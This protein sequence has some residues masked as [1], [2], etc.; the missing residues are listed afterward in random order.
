MRIKLRSIRIISKALRSFHQKIYSLLHDIGFICKPTQQ[1]MHLFRGHARV[2]T[3]AVALAFSKAAK[4]R[5]SSEYIYSGPEF[6]LVIWAEGREKASRSGLSSNLQFT[7]S[8][9]TIFNR[10]PDNNTRT[11]IKLRP[12]LARVSQ[13]HISLYFEPNSS[14][15]FVGRCRLVGFFLESDKCQLCN[16]A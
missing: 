2:C 15:F 11:A 7:R 4:R 9:S 3:R 1:F 12:V 6:T 14:H 16:A 5:G 8:G 13:L 10:N